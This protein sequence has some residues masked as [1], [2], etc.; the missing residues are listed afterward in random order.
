M[1]CEEE[2]GI[3]TYKSLYFVDT[4]RIIKGKPV[5]I[6]LKEIEVT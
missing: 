2:T 1:N 6:G 3:I 4:I 5:Y